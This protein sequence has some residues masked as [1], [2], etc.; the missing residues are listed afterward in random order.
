MGQYIFF[1]EVTDMISGT[2]CNVGQAPSCLELEFGHLMVQQ[3]DE[4]WHEVGV[5]DS[6]DWRVIFDRQKSSETNTCKQF[7]GGV[8][9]VDHFAQ[10]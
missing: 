7:N 6:L 3:L 2:G 1:D 4:D 8:L 9:T 5:D 10:I